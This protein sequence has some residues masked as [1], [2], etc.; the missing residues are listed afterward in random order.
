MR[1]CSDAHSSVVFLKEHFVVEFKWGKLPGLHL[2]YAEVHQ[3]GLLYPLID[4]PAISTGGS[5]AQTA[6]VYLFYHGADGL[7]VTWVFKEVAVGEGFS[8]EGL[9][10]IVHRRCA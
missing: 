5:Y 2:L 8:Y 10:C 4:D 7:G 3:D 9:C 6:F 1:D